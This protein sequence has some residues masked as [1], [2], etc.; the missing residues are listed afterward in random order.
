MFDQLKS[1][2]E[3]AENTEGNTGTDVNGFFSVISVFSV[4]EVFRDVC[5]DLSVAL[6]AR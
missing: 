1:A 6:L 5:N 3:R 2:T 4:A